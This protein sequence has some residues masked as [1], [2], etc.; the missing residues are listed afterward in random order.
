MRDGDRFGERMSDVIAIGEVEQV[1]RAVDERFDTTVEFLRE[2]VQAPSTLGAEEA[3]QALVER[4]L[5]EIGFTVSSVEVDPGRLAAIPESGLPLIPYEGRR[6]LVGELAGESEGILVLNGHVDVVSAEPADLWRVPPF[7]AVIEDGRM[8]GR[9]AADMKGGVAAML[10][11]VEAARSLGPL[12]MSV[13]YQSVIE[14]ESTG[15]GALAAGLASRAPDAALIAEPSDGEV[16]VAA[17]G[18]IYATIT[19]AGAGGHALSADQRVNPIDE[20]YEVIASL[21]RLEEEFNERP[22]AVFAGVERPYLLNIGALHAGDW[23]SN[24]PAKAQLD[25]R[26]G[27]PIALEPTTAQERLLA[28]VKRVAPH[29][30]VE[31][32]GQRAFGYSF[33]P[34]QPFVRL[35]RDCHEQVHGVAPAVMAGR[36]T[37]DLRFFERPFRVPGAACYGPTGGGYHGVDEW[38]DLESIRDVAAVVG[39]VLRRW[40]GAGGP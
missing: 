1:R 10:L 14:E 12:P 30:E 13:V 25:V 15:N 4:R 26:M 28:A 11:A 23:P 6:S 32:R 7:G 19:L 27:F 2:L 39:L 38:V 35:L 18:V 5:R 36:G 34:E 16:Y 21:R 24:T 31:F 22:D 20:A 17:V 3:A 33:D 37:T 9:G 29:A 40:R 8:Y